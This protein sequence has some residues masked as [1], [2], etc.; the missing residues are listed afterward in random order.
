MLFLGIDVSTS[1]DKDN[2]RGIFFKDYEAGF[3]AGYAVVHEGYNN[4]GYMG[5]QPVPAVQE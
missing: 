1:E 4:L 2:V 3:L 5:G